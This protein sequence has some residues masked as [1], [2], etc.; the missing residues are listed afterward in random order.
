MFV[1]KSVN[2][3]LNHDQALKKATAEMTK[4]WAITVIF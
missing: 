2:A 3:M 4:N 1:E